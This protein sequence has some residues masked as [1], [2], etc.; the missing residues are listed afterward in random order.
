MD[1]IDITNNI[2]VSV[3]IPIYNAYDYLR[4]AMDSVLAQTLKEIEIIC[5][6][7]GSTDHSLQI[8]KEYQNIDGRVR[9]VAENNAG[10]ALAR[11][12]GMRR[13]RGEFIAFLD[14]D[15]FFEPTMLEKLYEIAVKDNLDISIGR[16]DIYNSRRSRFEEAVRGDHYDIFTPGKVTSKNEYPDYIFTST[17][18]AAWNKLFR[19]SFIEE[20]GLRFLPDVKMY[21]DVY[22]TVTAI[23]LAERMG[24]VHEVL[25]HHRIHSEQARAKSFSKHYSQVAVV[26]HK[27]RE[28]LMNNG[29]YVPLKTSYLNLSASR[30]YKIY[31][32]L[33]QDSKEKFWN[34]LHEE[35]CELLDWRGKGVEEFEHTEVGE[36][37]ANVQL[38]DHSQYLRRAKKDKKARVRVVKTKKCGF[39]AK[40]FRGKKPTI[41]EN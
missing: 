23:S 24:K 40:L 2:K 7:D 26:Y 28:F 13:A 3:I 31:N 33:S 15:D 35:Y 6:D 14:A 12:N 22:F 34:L 27:I 38:Y 18:G 21:E 30:C 10:P 39:F 29:M 19:R 16:Y 9:I 41:T 17:S 37:V 25:I 11:N 1:N 20:K 32:V 8:I 5:I 4:T 36:F